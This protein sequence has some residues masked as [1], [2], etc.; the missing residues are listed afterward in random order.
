[1]FKLLFKYEELLLPW[2]SEKCFWFWV[3][4][5][6][7]LLFT[8]SDKSH[9]EYW[10]KWVYCSSSLADV[11]AFWIHQTSAVQNA[12]V[13]NKWRNISRVSFFRHSGL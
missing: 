3:S 2:L 8:P 10:H 7:K 12:A 6:W 9:A 11:S 1:M 4:H 5:A 13:N